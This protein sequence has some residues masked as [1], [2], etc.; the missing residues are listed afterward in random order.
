[1]ADIDKRLKYYNGQFLQDQDFTAEQ[2]Y[3]LDRLRRHNR[4]L[5]VPGIAFGLEV[6]ATVGATSATVAP[7]TATDKDGQ[8]IVLTQPRSV[9]F[10]SL[11]NQWVLVV[12]SYHDEPSDDATVGD[13]GPTR[14]LERPAVDA[15]PE[16]G[17]PAADVR[18]RLARLRIAANGTIAEQDTTVRALAGAKLRPEETLERLRLSRQGVSSNLWPVLSSGAASRADLAGD[19]SVTGNVSASNIIVTGNVDGRDVSADAA[20]NDTHRGRT[21]NPH[22]VTATQVGAITGVGGVLNPG[23]QVNLLAGTNIAITP[24][25]TGNK[26]IT[27]AGSSIDGVSN[28]GGNIDF[29]G[30][31]GI[32][33]TPDNTGKLI[34]FSTSPGAIG[35]LPIGDYLKRS[36]TYVLLFNTD[37][38]G[39]TRTITCNF[40]PKFIW[41]TGA[42]NAIVGGQYQAFSSTGFCKIDNTSSW[43]HYCTRYHL[44][45][46]ASAPYLSG[47]TYADQN[48]VAAAYFYDSTL[49]PNAHNSLTLRVTQVTTTG[50][51]VTLDRTSST[52]RDVT[53]F[54]DLQFAIFG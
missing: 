38:N 52:A 17:A 35:A 8:Q 2:D 40:E 22:S 14:Y 19:L 21:D 45:R 24:D 3:H 16:T 13:V 51:T 30:Q 41:V 43:T 37:G 7:G 4:Q 28:P 47:Y 6:T 49:N 18:I 29:V 39:A 11:T 33:I 54:I 31:N 53:M 20:L 9:A 26:R 12:I 32:S 46:S 15:I 25:N 10:G 44:T 34:A 1:M 48:G 27:I 42:M 36:T 5:H 50:F 23:G